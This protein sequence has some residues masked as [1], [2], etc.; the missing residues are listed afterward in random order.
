MPDV[1]QCTQ[2]ILALQL[3][4]WQIWAEAQCDRMQHYSSICLLFILLIMF[5][6]DTYKWRNHLERYWI[7][8]PCGMMKSF[9][10]FCRFPTKLSW[11]KTKGNA[12]QAARPITIIRAISS[13]Q[14]RKFKDE[15]CG[16]T[17]MDPTLLRQLHPRTALFGVAICVHQWVNKCHRYIVL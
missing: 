1:V 2:I 4:G 15:I 3:E 8:L 9:C 7:H 12:K 10:W 5:G 13:I 11:S 17:W 16:G 14:W 6:D